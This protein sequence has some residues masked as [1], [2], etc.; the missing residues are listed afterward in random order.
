MTDVP[1][2]QQTGT[3]WPLGPSWCAREVQ[4]SWNK[5]ESERGEGGKRLLHSKA[6]LPEA[7]LW[8]SCPYFVLQ[9]ISQNSSEW[10]A[11]F[12]SVRRGQVRECSQSS[13]VVLPSATTLARA[14]PT[15]PLRCTVGQLVRGF[16]F[17]LDLII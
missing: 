10:A 13:A 7:S 14:E 3:S 11:N 15:P 17:G 9:A 5:Y 8:A 12:F 6:S 2:R 4:G 1:I 16:A